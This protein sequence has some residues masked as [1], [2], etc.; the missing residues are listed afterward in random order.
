[1][2]LTQL[3]L[4]ENFK[5]VQNLK[6]FLKIKNSSLIDLKF[7]ESLKT[8]KC[9]DD[10]LVI[11]NNPELINVDILKSLATDEKCIWQLAKNPK[12]DVSKCSEFLFE[13]DFEIFGNFRDCEC[14]NL[15]ISSES[16]PYY[17]NC[18]TIS[19]GY[20]GVLKI[21][22]LSDSMYL[23]KFSNLRK[24]LGRIEVS[25]TQLTNLSFMGNLES[26][27]VDVNQNYG[28]VS[29]HDNPNLKFLGWNSLKK[30]VPTD[31]SF[32]LIIVDNHPEF[33]LSTQEAQIFAEISAVFHNEDK[34]L[35][36]PELTRTD[37]VK[38]CKI[39]NFEEGC[40]HVVGDVIIDENNEMDVW[41]FENVTHIFGNLVIRDTKELV[42]LS[43][44]SSLRSVIRLTK[45]IFKG[46]SGPLFNIF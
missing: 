16:L 17:T 23:S 30:I 46:K 3:E 40:H 13:N 43:F 35:L 27:T 8:S 5:N 19:G 31:Q 12:L 34:I 26:L 9:G 45:G 29:I 24:V 42:D 32:N 20:Q 38:V 11:A 18:K 4:K 33:C 1:M 25:R 2:D 21:K 14:Y 36:C 15:R 7:F 6:G 22:N 41:K 37:G 44:L 10:G 28:H 39:D